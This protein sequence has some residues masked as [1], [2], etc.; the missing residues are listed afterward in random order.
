MEVV[1]KHHLKHI[2][3]GWSAHSDSLG[4]SLTAHG[5]SH[6]VARANLA[7]TAK[8]FLQPALRRGDL[9]KEIEA[10]GVEARLDG[11]G[12]TIVLE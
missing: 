7:H 5:Y 2:K 1:L 3:H 6:E 10:M 11:D 4:V 8:L 9:D 12:L